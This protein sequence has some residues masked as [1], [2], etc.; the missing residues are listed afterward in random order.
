MKCPFN[1]SQHMRKIV[2]VKFNIVIRL[3]SAK[4][5]NYI[6]FMITVV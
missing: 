4:L 3:T 2:V 6:V 5:M 1:V